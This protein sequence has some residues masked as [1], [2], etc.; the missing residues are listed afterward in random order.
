MN[1]TKNISP[2][3]LRSRIK[4]L[5]IVFTILLRV[6]YLALS[7]PV[8]LYLF[9]TNGVLN[10]N[11]IF[12]IGTLLMIAVAVLGIIVNT[13]WHNVTSLQ[14]QQPSLAIHMST[15]ALPFV[16]F[17]FSVILLYLLLQWPLLE[18][19]VSVAY[20]IISEWYTYHRKQTLQHNTTMEPLLK[21]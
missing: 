1:E 3:Q 5:N 17:I 11:G 16:F 15:W 4:N 7:A 12:W 21:P 20:I 19:I 8:F 18:W 6:L 13:I 9:G 10:N 14:R 2:E